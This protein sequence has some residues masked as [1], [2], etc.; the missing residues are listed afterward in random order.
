MDQNTEL[1]TQGDLFKNPNLEWPFSTSLIK[2]SKTWFKKL[3]SELNKAYLL[4]LLDFLETESISGKQIYPSAD[5]YFKAFELCPFDNTKVIILGQDP[6]HGEGQAHGLSFSVP[7]DVQK[8]PPSLKNIFKEL[9]FDLNLPE[10]KSG[11]LTKWA[12]AGVLLLNT[13]LTVEAKKPASHKNQGWELFTDQVLRLL[14]EDSRP[15][16]FILWGSQAQSKLKVIDFKNH[17]ILQAPHPSPLSSYRGFFGS[18]PFSKANDYLIQSDQAPVDW[19][20]AD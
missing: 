5:N 14:V 18:K 20:L 4:K 16:V 8:L 19:S 11:D 6:Y 3:N 10:P 7:K 12:K 1:K 15:K 2:T 13:V 17:L 9:A